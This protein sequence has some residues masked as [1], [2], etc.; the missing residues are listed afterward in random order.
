MILKG[1]DKGSPISA[2]S[3]SGYCDMAE[4]PVPWEAG[5]IVNSFHTI[6]TGTAGSEEE[7]SDGEAIGFLLSWEPVPLTSRCYCSFIQPDKFKSGLNI[8]LNMA[9]DNFTHLSHVLFFS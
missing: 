7:I 8:R 9:L 5:D 3:D 6:L 4:K 1:P 2:S